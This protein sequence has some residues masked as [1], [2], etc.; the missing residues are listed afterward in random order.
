MTG[1]FSLEE[2]LTSIRQGK[3]R[4]EIEK[5]RA[6]VVRGEWKRVDRLKKQLP[7]VTFPACFEGGRKQVHLIVLDI[8]KVK[9]EGLERVVRQD[10]YTLACFRSP[11]G[12]GL[13]ILIRI[14]SEAELHEFAFGKVADYYEGLL[15]VEVDR[16]GKDITRLCFLSWDEGLYYNPEAR[17]FSIEVQEQSLESDQSGKRLEEILNFTQRKSQYHNGNRNNFLYQFAANCNR[18]GQARVEVQHY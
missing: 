9:V 5:I 13:K 15:G 12:M 8:D 11:G 2:I 6:A 3:Y 18:Q 10:E 1:L 7:A 16:S 4:R 17:V 14:D